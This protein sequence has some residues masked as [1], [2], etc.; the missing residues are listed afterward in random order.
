VCVLGLAA[1]GGGSAFG[2]SVV[3]YNIPVPLNPT[4][5]TNQISLTR[6]GTYAD[7]L[8]GQNIAISGVQRL[9]PSPSLI[10][11][12]IGC[13]LN[14]LSGTGVSYTPGINPANP[15]SA[16]STH[17][18]AS[19]GAVSI[20]GGV[21]LNDNGVLD[22]G[23]IAAGSTLLSGYFTNSPTV[24]A[25]GTGSGL[26]DFRVAAGLFLN[27]QNPLLNMYFFGN[28]LTNYWSGTMSLTFMRN[29][30]GVVGGIP[31]FTTHQIT[32]GF[33]R[34]EYPEPGSVLLF[35]TV[36]GLLALGVARRRKA[37]KA[38]G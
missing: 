6:S 18:F 24:V 34:N 13:V 20:V 28:P 21:D 3:L 2:G 33:V 9:E 4:A 17:T 27:N 10:R 25:L 7:M 22:G 26:G 32:D 1:L 16:G 5:T 8:R 38:E 31:T 12:C 15:S 19:G 11:S 36:A 29:H 35:S 37:A 14:F 30:T 23:D